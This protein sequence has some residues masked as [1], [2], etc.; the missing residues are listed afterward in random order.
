MPAQS[1]ADHSGQRLNSWKEIAV[2]FGK[3][4]R[5]VKRWETARGLPVRRVPGGTRTSVFAYVAELEAWLSAPRTGPLIASSAARAA[6]PSMRPRRRWL[7]VA[8]AAILIVA[9]AG[10]LRLVGQS[11]ASTAPPPPEALSLYND[12]VIAWNTRNAA[13]FQTAIDKFSA[14]LTIAPEFAAAHA[15]LANVYNLISQYTPTPAAEAYATARAEAERALALDPNS[16]EAYAALGFNA[17]YAHTDFTGSAEFFEKSLALAPDSP[18]TL[19]WYALTS[20]HTGN[21]TRPRQMIDRALALAPEARSIRAKAALI[22]YY[23]GDTEGAIAM[24]EQLR[25]ANPDYLA[26]PAYLATI[27]LDQRRYADYLDNYEITAR[28]EA[29]PGHQQI[30]QAAR[31]ALPQG[32]RAMLRAMLG[33]Q[34]RQYEAGAESA[35]K[36][37]ATA[38]V[39][40]ETDL[41]LSYLETAVSRRETL[42]LLV[43]PE[44]RSL[45]HEPRFVALLHTLGLPTE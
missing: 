29:S 8:A 19:Q 13:G 12:G 9:T 6:N 7:F 40:G 2:Y 17:F 24:L 16:A 41:A 33:E 34:L 45:R 14:A 39:L 15:G 35:Y 18:Q 22:H 30:A 20:M 28:V 42:A 43:E 38:A 27:Y 36:V 23:S 25:Q 3:D 32:G 5:T 4:E 1:S 37:A 31:A 10:L 11:S 21:F 44:F 26:V